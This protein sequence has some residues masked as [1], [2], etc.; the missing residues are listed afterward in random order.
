M[1]DRKTEP[2]VI[3]QVANGYMVRPYISPDCVTSSNEEYV[4]QSFRELS[5]HLEEHFT[6]RE[7][8]LHL[9]PS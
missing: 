1:S 4:F 3:F 9:D 8:E 2:I 7:T 5:Y 6:H